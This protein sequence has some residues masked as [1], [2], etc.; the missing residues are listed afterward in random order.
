VITV[1]N[2]LISILWQ[3]IICQKTI[4]PN[5][6]EPAYQHA[7]I[8]L[9]ASSQLTSNM[10]LTRIIR[11]AFSSQKSQQQQTV[12]IY[13]QSPSEQYYRQPQPRP[14][15]PQYSSLPPYQRDAGVY[16]QSPSEVYMRRDSHRHA[17]PVEL[18]QYQRAIPSAFHQPDFYAPISEYVPEYY[19]QEITLDA[20]HHNGKP[21]RYQ[22]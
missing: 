5:T 22:K 15:R 19:H 2:F 12:G 6:I 10:P 1:T 4:L 9:T 14:S 20:R 11:H 3:S 7:F 16:T 18:P 8:S 13:T 17:E 21:P